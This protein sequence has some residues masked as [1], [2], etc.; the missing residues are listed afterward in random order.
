[1]TEGP[2][3]RSRRELAAAVLLAA[4]GGA[5][6]LLVASRGWVSLRVDRQPP[7]PPLSRTIHGS[8]AQP[9]LN[10]L[11]F[12][13]L[14]GAVAILATRRIGRLLVGALL[15]AAGVAGLQRTVTDL[16]GMSPA[17]VLSLLE[18]AGPVVGIAAGARTTVH[19]DLPW[20]VC[21]LAAG[22]LLILGGVLT[23]VRAGAWPVMGR[24]YERRQGRSARPA[25]RTERTMWDALDRGD[26]PTTDPATDPIIDPPT[27]PAADPASSADDTAS[28]P[29]GGVSA[30]GSE[31]DA[32]RSEGG[33]R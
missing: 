14:A 2:P 25:A 32:H 1:M 29:D 17:H 7:L 18:D 28:D 15:V 21:A 30:G 27:D 13:G 23:I 19:P 12:V 11:G 26:D 31:P 33:T 4:V 6:L 22:C 3:P 8:D 16:N 24:R 10:A 20:M 9:L 5:L